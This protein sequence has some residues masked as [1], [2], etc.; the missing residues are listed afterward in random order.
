MSNIP[1]V[2]NSW[3]MTSDVSASLPPYRQPGLNGAGGEGAEADLSRMLLGVLRYKWMI[4]LA[5]VVGIALGVIASRRVQLEYVTQGTIWIQGASGGEQGAANRGPIVASQLLRSTAWV[6]L[7]RSFTVLDHVVRTQRLYVSTGLPSDKPLFANFDLQEKFTPGAFRFVVRA[8]GNGFVLE[9]RDGL[10]VETGVRGQEV[11]RKLGFV[12]TPPADAWEPGRVVDFSVANP[13]DVARGLGASLQPNMA[14][15]GRFL[16]IALPGT[17]TEAITTTLNAV[18]QR[19]VEVAAQLKR[20]NL[21]ELTEILEQQRRYAEDNLREAEMALQAFRVE[22]IT[23]PSGKGAPVAAG[24]DMTTDRVVSSFFEKKMA[25]DDMRSDEAALLNIL[26][27]SAAGQMTLD[28]LSAMPV[29]QSSPYVKNLLDELTL[30]RAELRVLQRRYTAENP[31]VQPVIATVERLEEVTIPAAVRELIVQLG[32]RRMDLE[33]EIRSASGELRQIPPR[34]IEEERLQR[35]VDIATTLYGTLR[36][37]FEEAR[38]AAV[39]SLADVQILDVATEPFQPVKDTRMMVILGLGTGTLGLSILAALLLSRQDRRVRYPEQITDGLGLPIL[40]AIPRV[41][42]KLSD[43][44]PLGSVQ[45]NEAFREL[46]LSIVHAHGAAGPLVLAVSSPESGDGK[47]TVAAALAH[48]FAGQGQRVVLIDGDI[49]RGALHRAMS[50]KRSPGLTD[51]LS[52]LVQIDEILQTAA[53]G[54]TT[55]GSGRRMHSGPEL[56]GSAAM[57]QLIRTLRSQFG[58][59]IVDTPPLGAGV[60]SYVIG[61]A[62]GNIV[63]VLRTGRTDGQIAEAK[64]ALL[65]RLPVRVLGAVL[66]DVPPSKLYRNYT[67]L[68]GYE[69]Q[70]EAEVLQ[71]TGG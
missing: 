65:D 12:W 14:P 70:E 30:K 16:R 33:T 61:T 25:L 13:R 40:G 59:I 58:V 34:Q 48:V 43:L 36:Q 63:L 2:P 47:S 45:M 32:A 50:V 31:Q 57:A 68:T 17:N 55:I 10:Q 53:N 6:D 29:A 24:I 27:Q 21:D 62:T 37:R 67:Y 41:K 35:R 51:Y 11:G 56:L 60:D 39:S 20:A 18:M 49:R 26:E 8:D 15:D 3:E 38:L 4:L 52:G 64:L 44:E 7:L 54:I 5:G 28:A 66:N 71:V 23:K 22:T 1:A 9:S 46:R 42:G 69:T 19:F